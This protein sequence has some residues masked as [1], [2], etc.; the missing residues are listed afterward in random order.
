MAEP[1]SLGVVRAVFYDIYPGDRLK[2]DAKSNREPG[3]GGGARD[4]RFSPREAFAGI[5]GKILTG[6]TLRISRSKKSGP[7]EIELYTGLVNWTDDS[8]PVSAAHSAVMTFWPFYSARSF[9]TRI[10]TVHKFGFSHLVRDDEKGGKSVFML[11]QLADG[12]VQVYFTTETSLREDRWNKQIKQ[13]AIRWMDSG[14]KSGFID[15]QDK[16]EFISG[17]S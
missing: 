5:F 15:L 17:D 10:A 2:L 3:D 7:Q 16:A 11:A 8:G 13:F 12:S 4:F 9:E 6:R 1:S 14:A